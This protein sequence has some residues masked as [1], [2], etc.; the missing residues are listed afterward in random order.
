MIDGVDAAQLDPG[1]LRRQIGVVLQENILF[2]RT[3]HENIALGNPAMPR[4]LVMQAAKLSG[5]DEFIVQLPQGY[6]TM[7][8]ERG[9]NLSGG[10]RQRI[11]IARALATNPRI[12]IFDEATSAL[13]YE[14]ERII[15]ENTRAIVR[16]RTVIIIAHRLAAVRTC[17]RIFSMTQGE[18]VEV[19]SHDE[20]DEAPGRA[21]RSPLGAAVRIREDVSVNERAALP[22]TPPHPPPRTP[23]VVSGRDRE[24]LPAALEILETPPPPLPIAFMATICAFALAALTWSFFGRLD[25]HAVAPGKIETAGHSKVI[26]PL[27][28]GKVTAIHVA[29]GQAVKAGALLFELD[30]TEANA[31]K[32]SAADA[33]NASLGEIAR[34]RYAIE[35]VRVAQS[36]EMHGAD[37][38][39]A[40]ATDSSGPGK[41]NGSMAAVSPVENLAGQPDIKIVWDESLPEPFRLREEAVLRADLA[42]LAD[43]L[44]ALDKQM[45]QKLA[46]RKRLDMSIGFQHTLM[47]TLNQR[48]L[49]RQQAIDLNVGTKINL[50]DAKEELEKSQS[51]L[52]SDEGQLIE[53]D[54]ALE[55]L[56]SEKAKVVSQFIADNE[57]KLAGA[58]RKADE[59]R[60]ALVKATARLARTKL[61][62]PI[63]GVVQQMAVTT[64]GQVVT[65][66]QQLAV[67]TP[68]GGKL[69]VEALVPNL[70]IGFIKPGQHAAIKIDAFPFTRFGVLHGKSRGDC[71]RCDR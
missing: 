67:I 22:A 20:L 14:S 55:E 9:A 41:P 26:G 46:T 53:N 71:S 38:R 5:A 51:Q 18:I 10:Q 42:Q 57:N 16:G 37:S 64:V 15:Q 19:G 60:Q 39:S 34:R 45:A 49:T 11:A 65:T 47:D 70:D 43:S 68:A 7:I 23:T 40:A 48:V 58:S 27:D 28:A 36:E 56:Q 61:T 62:A 66:G 12:L 52:A 54:A 25:V 50:Y 21:L 59:A 3:V 32:R 13:D 69:Q 1:W 29:V 35:A 63:D 8:E 44:K 30:P 24:F 31:D 17:T 2:N 6:D 4:V 33:L